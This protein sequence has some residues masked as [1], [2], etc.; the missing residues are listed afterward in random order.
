MAVHTAKIV[1]QGRT[2]QIVNV[3]RR[4]LIEFGPPFVMGVVWALYNVADGFLATYIKEFSLAFFMAAW[5][6]NQ[7]LRIIYQQGQ[8]SRMAGLGADLDAIKATMTAMKSNI[9][10]INTQSGPELSPAVRELNELLATANNQIAS[11]NN[12]FLA[13]TP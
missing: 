8:I 9:A 10:T 6:W 1:R 11:A 12:A 7:L 3:S 5:I 2:Q 13:A 4:V